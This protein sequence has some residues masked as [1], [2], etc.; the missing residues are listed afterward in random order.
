MHHPQT[1]IAHARI[2]CWVEL[3]PIRN[4]SIVKWNFIGI[5]DH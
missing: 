5:I 3:K 4:K 2:L 1:G